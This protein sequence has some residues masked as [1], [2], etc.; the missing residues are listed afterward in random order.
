MIF[1]DDDD[2]LGG[3][4]YSSFQIRTDSEDEATVLKGQLKSLHEKLDQLLLAS[5]ASSSEA[6]SKA[7]VESLFERTTKE[8]ANNTLKMIKAVSDSTKVC[9]TTI[10]KFDKLIFEIT[11]LMENYE[12]N[13]NTNTASANEAL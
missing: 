13:Y 4:T 11:A 5:K 9:K 7:A 12:S 2:N 10:E 3:F 1:G 6:Y 8:H